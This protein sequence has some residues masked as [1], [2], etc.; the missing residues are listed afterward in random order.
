MDKNRLQKLAGIDEIVVKPA[1]R[2]TEVLGDLIDEMQDDEQGLD[3]GLSPS[4]LIDYDE[5]VEE[6]ARLGLKVNIKKLMQLAK[7]ND[8]GFLYSGKEMVE[9]ALKINEIVVK[10]AKQY[11]HCILDNEGETLIGFRDVDNSA[12]FENRVEMESQK[13]PTFK[14]AFTYYSD[15]SPCFAY[16]YPAEDKEDDFTARFGTSIP[17][18]QSPCAFEEGQ[19]GEPNVILKFQEWAD[20]ITEGWVDDEDLDEIVVKPA[21]P[22]HYDFEVGDKVAYRYEG[23][24]V[25]FGQVIDRV[26]DYYGIASKGGGDLSNWED[27][28]S[29][30]YLWSD[31][32]YDSFEDWE[33]EQ[34]L[35]TKNGV[36]YKIR[37]KNSKNAFIEDDGWFPAEYVESSKGYRN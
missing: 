5:V 24:E 18:I 2:P 32:G 12:D 4:E 31:Y 26:K 20:K 11:K 9:R 14:N 33:Q 29:S 13:N 8:T 23:D 30:D 36:W 19:L 25:E 6:A 37:N 7:A 28:W 17:K 10:P 22:V 21:S 35:P 3:Q 27:Y 16:P 15:N 1:Q 34:V